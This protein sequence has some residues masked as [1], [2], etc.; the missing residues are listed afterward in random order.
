MVVFPI[1]ANGLRDALL[2]DVQTT[3]VRHEQAG[4]TG[5]P[6]Y[7]Q[8]MMVFYERHVIR[9]KPIPEHVQRAMDQVGQVYYTMNGPSEFHV[10]GTI[11]DWDRTDRLSDIHVPTLITSG[12]YD[13][14]TPLINEVLHKGIAGSEWVLFEQSSHMAHVEERELYLSTVKAFIENVEA[15]LK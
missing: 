3:L 6:E 10:I 12:R 2:P 4:T 14:S 15:E 7:Q 11:K 5:D 9:L 13:K 8:A 1:E